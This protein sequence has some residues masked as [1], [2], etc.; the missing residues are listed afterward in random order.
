M[1][2]TRFTPEQIAAALAEK[3][4]G[5]TVKDLAR[6]LGVG[7]QTIY[8]WQRKFGGMGASEAK[9]LKSLEEENRRLQRIV[10]SQAVD[11]T[12]LKDLLGK[13]W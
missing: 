9:R 7:E 6:E 12:V 13:S 8:V 2:K 4:A 3:A 5:K 1:K 10:A 11:I